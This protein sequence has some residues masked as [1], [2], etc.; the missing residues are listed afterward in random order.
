VAGGF[1]PLRGPV[2]ELAFWKLSGGNPP[3]EIKAYG[4]SLEA[5][6]GAALQGLKDLVA[7]FDDEATPYLAA[8]RPGRAPRYSDYNHLARAKE[9]SAGTQGSEGA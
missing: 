5:L 9:W 1:E 8:P 6:A 2:A 3:G 4:D 7:R